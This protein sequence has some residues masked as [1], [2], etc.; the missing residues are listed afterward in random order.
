MGPC[1]GTTLH[2]SQCNAS[3]ASGKWQNAF[4]YIVHKSDFAVYDGNIFLTLIYMYKSGQSGVG[5]YVLLLYVYTPCEGS[6]RAP[7]ARLVQQMDKN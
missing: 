5:M 4:K 1:H 7:G 3:I 6:A 2:Y